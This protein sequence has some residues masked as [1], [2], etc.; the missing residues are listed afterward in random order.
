M[1]IQIAASVSQPV[2]VFDKVFLQRL[3]IDQYL[4]VDDAPLPKYR[5]SIEYRLYGVVDG[6]RH[7]HNDIRELEVPDFVALATTQAQAGDFV[8]AQALPAIELAIAKLVAADLSTTAE[9]V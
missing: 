8:L 3:S 1:G 5:V 2:V 7:F 9:V 6:V 4:V